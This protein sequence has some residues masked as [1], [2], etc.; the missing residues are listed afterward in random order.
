MSFE[1]AMLQMGGSVINFDVNT[2]GIKK[3][4]TFE[5]TLKT[6]QEFRYDCFKTSRKT[7]NI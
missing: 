1:T 6:L 7:K 3:G 2:S 4:E 5:D